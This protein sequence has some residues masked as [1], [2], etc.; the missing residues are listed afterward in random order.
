MGILYEVFCTAPGQ[1][2]IWGAATILLLGLIIGYTSLNQT[3]SPTLMSTLTQAQI[4]AD[5]ASLDHSGGLGTDSNAD[6][7]VSNSMGYHFVFFTLSYTVCMAEGAFSFSAPILAT[8]HSFKL[9]HHITCQVLGI[10]FFIAGM[11]NIVEG[12]KFAGGNSNYHVYSLHAWTG[13]VVLLMQTLVFLSGLSVFV[14][15]KSSLSPYFLMKY[16][17]WH[18]FFG[19]LTLLFALET[20]INGWMDWQ[21]METSGNQYDYNSTSLCEAA[22]SVTTQLQAGALMIYFWITPIMP[23]PEFVKMQEAAAAGKEAPP[24]PVKEPA[25][26]PGREEEANS[27]VVFTTTTG[28]PSWSTGQA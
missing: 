10:V 17:W 28:Q 1:T 2:R 21:S 25:P 12:K 23:V 3:L 13:I 18:T 26:L 8:S 4:A 16:S 9:Y 20:C 27:T 22:I 24:L 15:F 7:Y 14:L 11:V 6:F 5:E 19:R